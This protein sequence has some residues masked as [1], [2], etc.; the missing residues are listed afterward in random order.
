LDFSD[1]C[2]WCHG[3]HSAPH[4]VVA[5]NV[6]CDMMVRRLL[7]RTNRKRNLESFE[8]PGNGKLF[9]FTI[10]FLLNH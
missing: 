3:L 2:G 6:F 5:L 8:C 1:K 9:S 4:L 7:Q 10:S